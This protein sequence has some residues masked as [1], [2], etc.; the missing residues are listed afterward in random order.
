[1][2]K[3]KEVG[4][5]ASLATVNGVG[6]KGAPKLRAAGIRTT[7]SLLGKGATRQG[8]KE[9]SEQSGLTETQ[10]LQ[11][12]NHADLFR[13]RGAGREYVELLEAA[14]VATVVDLSLR[15]AESLHQRLVKV[16]Q[17]R[18]LVRKVPTLTQ[19]RTWVASAKLLP[20]AVKY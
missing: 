8:R 16:N 20:R 13:I 3:E 11:L 9:I 12:V 5:V 2:L 6:L 4:E 17:K 19:V 1:M 10:V 15:A 18:K 7:H 14:G